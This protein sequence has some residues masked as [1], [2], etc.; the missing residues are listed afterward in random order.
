MVGELACLSSHALCWTST[1]CHLTL[2][3][4]G[5]ALGEGSLHCV[6]KA[7]VRG[8]SAVAGVTSHTGRTLYAT[9]ANTGV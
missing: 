1:T 3:H 6:H 5:S 8:K 7:R 4:S 9:G 2:L